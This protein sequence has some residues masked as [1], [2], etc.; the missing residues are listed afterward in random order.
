MLEGTG[1]VKAV[2]TVLVPV[3]VVVPA[4]Q[5][6]AQKLLLVMEVAQVASTKAFPAVMVP[7][8]LAT[9][10]TAA[11][12]TYLFA[13]RDPMLVKT[14]WLPAEMVPAAAALPATP[15]VVAHDP[16]GTG[17]V[18]ATQVISDVAQVV[19]VPATVTYLPAFV[20]V[21]VGVT[22]V[23]ATLPTRSVPPP[24]HSVNEM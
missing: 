21:H 23:A 9:P 2:K 24:R 22:T 10:T 16:P 18:K 13:A 15:A 8:A 7:S 5:L 17:V 11:V 20:V 6:V 12:V 3:D 1:V 19:P 14:V 4:A